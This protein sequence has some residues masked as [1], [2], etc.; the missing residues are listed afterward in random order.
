MNSPALTASRLLIA[1]PSPH[2]HEHIAGRRAN[3]GYAIQSAVDSAEA[4]RILLDSSATEIA[5][6]DSALPGQSAVELAADV[7]RRSPDK[8]LWIIEL[9][10]TQTDPEAIALAA[11]AGID[12]LL[13]CPPGDGPAE[14]DLRIRLDVARRVI[15]HIQRIEARVQAV[16]LHLLQDP[17]TGLWNRE[18]MLSLLF[19][20]T[21]RVQRMGT[22]LSFLLLD[23]DHFSRINTEHG[24]EAGDKILHEM[25]VRLRRYM[26]SYDLLGRCGDDEFLLALPGCN[27]HQARHLASRIRTIMLHKPF[28]AADGTIKVTVSIGLA[29][30]R[31]RSPLVSLREAENSLATA[32]RDGRNCER[33]FL[34]TNQER[35]LPDNHRA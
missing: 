19:T 7:K 2:L 9:I 5:L 11:D 31:G 10:T 34:T 22:P 15:G 13:L 33:E 29:Q 16:S 3:H 25:A 35:A 21:D 28:G 23:I 32:K 30:S 1:T 12:D 17:L 20:E 8:P 14:I 18:S 26:R 27:T 4:S 24:Y 6:L